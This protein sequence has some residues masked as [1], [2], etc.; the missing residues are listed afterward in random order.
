MVKGQG[1]MGRNITGVV[2]VTS[3]ARMER[4][5]FYC[6]L[7]EQLKYPCPPS[8]LPLFPPDGGRGNHLSGVAGRDST[9][10]VERAPSE[11][12]RSASKEPT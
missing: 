4:A 7:W 8:L 3:T 12:A 5:R 11:S 1:S 2:R 9:A 10:R 6:A